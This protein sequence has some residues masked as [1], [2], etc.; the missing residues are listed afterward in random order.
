MATTKFNDHFS[1][2]QWEVEDYKNDAPPQ[3]IFRIADNTPC[4]EMMNE[5]YET[6]TDY[7]NFQIKQIEKVDEAY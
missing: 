4:R 6:A 2:I 5:R 1:A 7:F 3:P